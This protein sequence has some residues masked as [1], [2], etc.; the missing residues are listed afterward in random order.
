MTA[1]H[2]ALSVDSDVHVPPHHNLIGRRIAAGFALVTTV[3]VIMCAMLFRAIGK[4][5]GLVMEM[6]ADERA[7]DESHALATAVREQ[8]THQAHTII[9]ASRSHLAH[10]QTWVDKVSAT[11]HALRPILRGPER[12]KLDSVVAK[13]Q[14]LDTMFREE[15][16]PA[17]EREDHETV[18]RV[19]HVADH[20]S[21][22]AAQDADAIAQAVALGMVEAHVSATR[23]TQVGLLGGGI[24]I[25]LVLALAIGYTLRLRKAVLKPLAALA[26]AA[27]RFG[28]GDYSARLGALGEGEL[29]AVANAFD[30]MAEAIEA[31]ERRMLQ[32]ERMAVIGKLAAG[33]AHEINNPIGIIRGYLKTMTAD[34]P[35]EMLQEELR[36]L[37]EEAATCQRIAEDLLMYA[38]GSE[39]RLESVQ[40]REFLTESLRRF[41]DTGSERNYRFVV[42]A[43]P[44]TLRLD[45]GR[46]R[47]VLFNLLRNAGRAAPAGSPIEVVGTQLADGSYEVAVADRG[48]GIDPK[49]RTLIFEPFYSKIAGGSGL[50]LAMCESIIRAHGGTITVEDNPG[51][52]AIFR[53]RLSSGNASTETSVQ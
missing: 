15:M 32:A 22:A 42:N 9:E 18:A 52:G 34:S 28:G 16:I 33:V 30:H 20:L 41:E 4:V 11:A 36:I 50:G 26:E 35:P 25:S 40:V 43:Q 21:S 19:H 8:Y 39:L 24:C 6:R 37:D 47:Q 27:R 14:Q 7:I 5:S 10:Y 12:A 45:P 29:R 44:R 2:P 17:V 13:S 53:V 3:A 23:A 1:K 31:R 38:T 48:P 51:G 49:E 46:M